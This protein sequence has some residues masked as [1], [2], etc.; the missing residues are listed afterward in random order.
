I[1]NLCINNTGNFSHMTANDNSIDQYLYSNDFQLT[2]HCPDRIW[3]IFSP[4]ASLCASYERTKDRI[5][6]TETEATIVYVTL[7]GDFGISF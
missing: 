5:M 2:Y 7:S 4:T 6:G 1:E 3:G